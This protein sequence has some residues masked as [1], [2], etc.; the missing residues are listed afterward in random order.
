[1]LHRIRRPSGR[2][3][4]LAAVGAALLTGSSPAIAQAACPTTPESQVFA[5]FKDTAEYSL[6][7]GGTFTGSTSGWSLDGA[8][9]TSGG[10]QL[11]SS[12]THSLAIPATS[13][14]TSPAFCVSMANPT[15]RFFARQ[16][17]GSWATM[18]VNLVWTDSSGTTHT[19]TVASLN[20]TS[21]WTLTPAMALSTTLPLWQPG[22]TLTTRL[23]FVPEAYGGNWAI[24]DLYVDPYSRG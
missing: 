8:S 3:F 11:V 1:M 6:V 5:H 2:G 17:S 19:T 10:A 12:D 7:A 20:G 9:V 24:D 23:Q 22:Q 15:F 16:T 4:V 21:S 18:L 14:V 13:V